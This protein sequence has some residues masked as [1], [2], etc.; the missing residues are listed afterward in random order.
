MK[1]QN[2]SKQQ[3]SS[4]MSFITD[5]PSSRSK[6]AMNHK[7]GWMKMWHLVLFSDEDRTKSAI[8]L[9][10]LLLFCFLCFPFCFQDLNVLG[11]SFFWFSFFIVLFFSFFFVFDFNCFEFFVFL[12]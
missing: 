11:R 8:H 6:T 1:T 7:P 12:T 5:W 9:F 10:L 3:H 2:K 4:N